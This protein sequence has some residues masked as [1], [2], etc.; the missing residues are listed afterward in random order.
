[1]H[2]L[3]MMYMCGCLHLQ[4]Q[5]AT[6]CTCVLGEGGVRLR[7]TAR[8]S[9]ALRIQLEGVELARKIYCALLCVERAGGA[10]RR[11]GGPVV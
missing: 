5:L 11:R 2:A 8:E 4:G 6:L 10:L 1:M 3:R 9:V 7:G